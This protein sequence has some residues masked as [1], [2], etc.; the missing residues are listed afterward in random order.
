[1]VEVQT[2]DEIILEEEKQNEAPIPRIVDINY[3]AKGIPQKARANTNTHRNFL[4]LL[5]IAPMVLNNQISYI[6]LSAGEGFMPLTIEKIGSNRISVSHHY[7]QNGD[8][9]YDPE[10]VCYVDEEKQEL[11]PREYRQD[12]L[13]LYQTV[14]N[15]NGTVNMIA[16][17]ELSKFTV[18]WFNNIKSQGYLTERVIYEYQS[19]DMDLYFNSDKQ[20]CRIDSDLKDQFCEENNIALPEDS[21]KKALALIDKYNQEEFGYEEPGKYEDIT[22]IGLAF[23]TTEN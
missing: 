21:L 20:L 12:N 9:M 8:L 19:E 13:G 18:T 15:D 16:E 11:R 1:M 17:A 10:I 22:N 4:S 23:T 14:E 5:E 2:T 3:F 7:T 6:R